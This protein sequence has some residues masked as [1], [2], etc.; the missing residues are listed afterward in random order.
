[1]KLPKLSIKFKGRYRQSEV[2]SSV[3]TGMHRES[4]DFN[5]LGKPPLAV[6]SGIQSG[7]QEVKEQEKALQDM[8]NKIIEENRK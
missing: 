2:F 4:I 5:L 3:Y 7:P 6:I 8:Y 1:M